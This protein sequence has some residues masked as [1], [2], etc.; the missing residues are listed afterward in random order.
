MLSMH[1]KHSS[2]CLCWKKWKAHHWQHLTTFQEPQLCSPRLNRSSLQHSQWEDVRWT[3][4]FVISMTMAGDVLTSCSTTYD[5]TIFGDSHR[6]IPCVQ[7]WLAVTIVQGTCTWRPLAWAEGTLIFNLI[8]QCSHPSCAVN[9]CWV[10]KSAWFLQDLFGWL[11]LKKCSQP[12]L[13][14]LWGLWDW[15]SIPVETCK[16]L[17]CT[18]AALPWFHH[19]WQFW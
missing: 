6:Q 12:I 3:A 18:H 7:V 17:K 14:C 13:P 15:A 4:G 16:Q 11:V 8:I 2:S 5:Q 1:L 9:C 19:F 10:L